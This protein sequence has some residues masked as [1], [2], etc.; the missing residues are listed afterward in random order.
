MSRLPF[1]ISIPHGGEN[2]P[3]EVQNSIQ[4]TRE[5]IIE[6]GDAFTR[7]IYDIYP[8][9][10]IIK[11][12]IARAFIDLNRDLKSIPP[13]HQDGIIKEKTCY[14]KTI[15]NN[16]LFPNERLIQN[17]IK[18]YYS[19]YYSEIVEILNSEN[20]IL[21]LDCHSMAATAPPIS[22]QVGQR[23]P[24]INLGNVNG[25]AC[26][27]KIVETLAQ[28]FR[29]QF[30]IEGKDVTINIP[31]KGGHIIK[32]FGKNPIPWIQIEM[33]RDL[34]LKE[35]WFIKKTWEV[36]D[37]RL[38]ELNGLFLKVLKQF[39]RLLKNNN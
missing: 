21:G 28:C 15:Y 5:D 8:N 4:I 27:N 6:D 1:L 17:L 14:L 34:Y 7:Q 30:K 32:V 22:D 13:E 9:S 29:E 24:L 23:R 16:G 10:W 3:D 19:P 26:D 11:A 2:I 25:A 12:D 18:K 33:N 37:V 20:I 31:F 39:N 36:D 35:P 38:K